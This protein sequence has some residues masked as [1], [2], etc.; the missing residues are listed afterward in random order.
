MLC[1]AGLIGVLV[2]WKRNM[3]EFA[4][5]VAWAMFAICIKNWETDYKLVSYAALIVAAILFFCAVW[6]AY[7]NQDT[8]PYVKWQQYKDSKK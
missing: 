5:V 7:L 3:R 1:I 8:A 6:H 2:T 4:I